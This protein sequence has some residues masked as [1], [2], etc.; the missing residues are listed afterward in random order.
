M[1]YTL[2]DSSTLCWCTGDDTDM[3]GREY[4]IERLRHFS[5]FRH[6]NVHKL[7]VLDCAILFSGDNEIEALLLYK[8]FVNFNN[9]WETL[10]E[11]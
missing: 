11:F 4:E 7:G 8:T 6:T 1:N 2:C 9:C 10:M 3:Y 5:H